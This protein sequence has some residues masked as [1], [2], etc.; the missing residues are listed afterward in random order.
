MNP[1]GYVGGNPE[2]FVDPTG[3]MYD[4]EVPG[5]GEG[6]G[7]AGSGG[8]GGGFEAP[9][10]PYI[11]YEEDSDQVM[12]QENAL[13]GLDAD[14]EEQMQ[15]VE[16]FQQDEEKELQQE[17]EQRIREEDQR[18]TQQGETHQGEQR[19]TEN[20]Q[21]RENGFPNRFPQRLTSEQEDAQDAGIQTMQ[22]GDPE[23]KQAI[24]DAPNGELPIKWAVNTDG[25][26]GIIPDVREGNIEIHHS[27]I[28][29][30]ENV[31]SAGEGSLS[32]DENGN[33][34]ANFLDNNSGHYVSGD[35][36]AWDAAY[37]EYGIPAFIN[38]GV[39]GAENWSY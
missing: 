23:L 7:E 6:G 2:T 15:Q 32:L 29:N 35:L 14:P 5:G 39:L 26:L 21:D 37:N 31:L 22:P 3:H 25:E 38:A 4:P 27:V 1:Y 28:W 12:Q 11:N 10:V 18:E 13:D 36:A 30:G 24:E 9:D 33:L 16:R 34:V 17:E 19:P 8:S 20:N